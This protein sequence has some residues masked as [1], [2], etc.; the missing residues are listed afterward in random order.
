MTVKTLID[1][2]RSRKPETVIV[3]AL[4]RQAGVCFFAAFLFGVGALSD[5]VRKYIPSIRVYLTPGPPWVI[6]A[7]IILAVIFIYDGFTNR[8]RRSHLLRLLHLLRQYDRF[9][10]EKEME[11]V[12][13]IHSRTRLAA[14]VFLMTSFLTLPLVVA[15]FYS[16][17]I[18]IVSDI[19]NNIKGTHIQLS[20]GPKLF[21][22]AY[23]I[24]LGLSFSWIFHLL[25]SARFE[26]L[27]LSGKYRRKMIVD[28]RA[29]IVRIKSKLRKPPSR[30]ALAQSASVSS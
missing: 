22:N 26:S 3:D 14:L 23:G 28:W 12:S 1:E 21:L 9:S 17:G 20:F 19:T 24:A 4:I 13:R 11:V 15:F 29:R 5:Y 6:G 2:F 30:K 10:H 8:G 7:A 25:E 16:F 18:A 27:L